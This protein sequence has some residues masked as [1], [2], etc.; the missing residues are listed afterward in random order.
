MHDASFSQQANDFHVFLYRVDQMFVGK[1]FF[2]QKP[3]RRWF[4]CKGKSETL[5]FERKL[6]ICGVAF[7]EK[8]FVRT[9]L[10]NSCTTPGACTIKLITA[11]IYGFL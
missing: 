5:V 2:G 11:V 6:A 7:K 3:W 8:E 4:F 1:M 10:F 9:E